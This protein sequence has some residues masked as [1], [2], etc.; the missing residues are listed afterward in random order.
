MNQFV[1]GI[2]K[3][4]LPEIRE[5]AAPVTEELLLSVIDGYNEQLKGGEERV[6]IIIDDVRRHIIVYI[7]AMTPDNR[8]KRVIRKIELPELMEMLLSNV[9]KI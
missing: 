7:C 3:Q 1:K 4:F 6:S 2:I 8:V 9:D 5:K